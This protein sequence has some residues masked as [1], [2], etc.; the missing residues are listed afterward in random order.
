MG[1]KRILLVDDDTSFTQMLRLNLEVE[2]YEVAVEND[3][4]MAKATALSFAPHV[5]LLDVIMPEQEGPDV[6]AEIHGDEALRHIP[7]IFLT[8]TV[9]REETREERVI[10]GHPFVAK[11]ADLDSLLKLIEETLVKNIF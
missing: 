5:I 2:G 4:R 8:A 1:K 11:P 10:G 6:F 9:T 3:P 7:I